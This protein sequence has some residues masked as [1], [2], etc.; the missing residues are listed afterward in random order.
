MFT[1]HW[2]EV[3]PGTVVVGRMTLETQTN[4]LFSCTAEFDGYPATQVTA[5][6]LPPMVDCVLTLESYGIGP[7]APYPQLPFTEFRAISIAPDAVAANVRWEASGGAVVK[8]DGGTRACVD[9]A[10]VAT[11]T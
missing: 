5:E 9:G 8:R 10:Y 3:A 6:N 4:G 7:T 11:G 1:T 2:E